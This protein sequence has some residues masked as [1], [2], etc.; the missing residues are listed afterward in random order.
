M[1]LLVQYCCDTS[2]LLCY[3]CIICSDGML[4]S[5]HMCVCL[6]C[7]VIIF[8]HVCVF[9][10]CYVIICSHVVPTC[11]CPFQMLCYFLLTCCPSLPVCFR[12]RCWGPSL[13]VPVPSCPPVPQGEAAQLRGCRPRGWDL[14]GDGILLHHH[15]R[16]A[17]RWVGRHSEGSR[18]NLTK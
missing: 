10:R 8:S 15:P 1:S 16:P 5:A 18:N 3:L 14:P 13:P 17:D 11:V 7:N 2:Y 12:L 4:L 9:L 6:R